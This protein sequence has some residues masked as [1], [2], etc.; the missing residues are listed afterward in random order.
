[1][2]Q[3]N[4]VILLAATAVSYACYV[5][6]EQNPFARYASSALATIDEHSLEPVTSREL[7]DAAISGMVD[8]LHDHGDPHSQFFDERQTE[9]LLGE[10]RQHFGGIGVRIHFLGKPPRLM[11][12]APPEPDTPAARARLAAGDQILAIDDRPTNQ[13]TMDDVLVAMRGPAGQ[14]LRLAI[15]RPPDEK[16]RTVELVR[17]NITVESV[18]G[19]RRGDDGR[20]QFRLESD[21][22]VAHARITSFGDLSAKE[23]DRL[24]EKLVADGVQAVALDLRD[25]SGGTLEAAVDICG[26]LLPQNQLVVETRGR[27]GAARKRYVTKKQ[28]RFLDPPLAVLV[29]QNSASASE[30]VAACLQDHGRAVVVGQRSYGKGTVQQLIATQSGKSVLK[31]TWASFWRPS[32]QNIHRME[33]AQDDGLWG[34]RPDAGHDVPLSNDEY[35]E[36]RQFRNRRDMAGWIA[37]LIDDELP[38]VPADY[39]DRQLARAV[40][41][42]QSVL[43]QRIENQ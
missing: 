25:N 4:L 20:W 32:G 21:P 30:I 16:P 41:H 42:L 13:M 43:D 37:G 14:P 27:E 2:S 3:R 40:E 31:L 39:E 6:G 12:I 7:F 9:A 33:A 24:L 22:R 5:R 29:N 10:I 36:Y 18:L 11:V 28:G 38:A 34:V 19:D 8:V 26:L 1:M 23:L 15:Q 17:E 35:A